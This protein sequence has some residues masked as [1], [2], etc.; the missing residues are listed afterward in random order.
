LFNGLRLKVVITD[1]NTGVSLMNNNPHRIINVARVTT[2][3]LSALLSVGIVLPINAKTLLEETYDAA[4]AARDRAAQ[5]RDRAK[6]AREA[7]KETRDSMRETRQDFSAEVLDTINE[8]VDDVKQMIADERAGRKEFTDDDDGCSFLCDQFRTDLLELVDNTEDAFN[9]ILDSTGLP[10]SVNFDKERGV[11]RNAPGRALYPL[12]R[13]LVAGSNILNVVS[14]EMASVNTNLSTLNLD[15][16][17]QILANPTAFENAKKS[18]KGSAK[19]FKLI[20]SKLSSSGETTITEVDIGL[21]GWA[22]VT[23]KTNT[24]KT[25]ASRFN[26][27]SDSLSKIES[28]A[29][30]KQNYC[31]IVA[32]QESI[33]QV[34]QA[35]FEEVC[36]ISRYRS[37]NCQALLLP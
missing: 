23:A 1:E 19:V 9:S 4:I 14:S 16:C 5:A 37:D 2:L 10:V 22:H 28:T 27:L 6:E 17:E 35:L 32:G 26:G 24:E 18:V 15:A 3:L 13:S 34:Q 11:V 20:G 25:W 31:T 29:G 12:Y 8:G 30:D 33:I 21:W 7:A 36:A